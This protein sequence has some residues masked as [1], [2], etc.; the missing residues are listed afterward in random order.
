MKT[1]AIAHPNIALIKYWGKRDEAEALPHNDSL[2][3]TWEGLH[4]ITTLRKADAFSFV[5][6]GIPAPP[7]AVKKVKAFLH[8]F[9][10]TLDHVSVE[11][12]NTVPTGAGFASSAS[13]FAALGVAANHFFKTGFSEKTLQAMVRKGSGSAVRSLYG[14]AVIFKRDGFAYPFEA[15]LENIALIPVLI[16]ASLKPLSSREAMKRSVLTSPFYETFVGMSN[17]DVP[18]MKAAL[19]KGTLET[20]GPLSEMHAHALHATMETSRPPIR[21]LNDASQKVMTWVRQLRSQGYA[22]YYTMDAGPNVKVLT[23][24]AQAENIH[25]L[26]L[27]A[28]FQTLGILKP[29][30]EGARIIDDD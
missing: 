17:A 15:S 2:S 24:Q 20:I 8:Y 23:T 14:G 5:L 9:T 19:Q 22:A 7:E 26:L 12:E 16:D 27:K 18:K 10:D 21:Y 6:N 25:A 29:A 11:S 13:A 28:G 3:I 30:R 1:T 4:T